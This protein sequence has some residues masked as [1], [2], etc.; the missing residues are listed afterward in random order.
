MSRTFLV[1][2]VGMHFRPPAKGI[3]SVLPV[4]Q[5]LRLVAEPDNEFDPNAIMVLVAS[6]AIPPEAHEALGEAV[7]AYGFSLE[8]ILGE[9]EWHLGY[10]ARDYAAAMVRPLA[11]A[12]DYVAT[13]QINGVGKYSAHVT[14]T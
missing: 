6:A 12:A 8:D 7:A 11:E 14:L 13:L 1:P 3:I 2:V 4:G 10:V 5:A 9:A